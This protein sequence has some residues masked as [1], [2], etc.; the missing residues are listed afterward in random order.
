MDLA[1]VGLPSELFRQG[2]ART[3]EALGHSLDLVCLDD[4]TPFTRY[5]ARRA[6]CA[7]WHRVRGQTS[8]YP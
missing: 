5:Y 1:V 3:H 6:S 7:V 4:D 2:M 8:E